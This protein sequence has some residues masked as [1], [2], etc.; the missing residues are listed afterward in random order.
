M[1]QKLIFSLLL[2][3]F[4]SLIAQEKSP[5]KFGNINPGDFNRKIYSIDSSATAIV[6]AN[7]GSTDIEGNSKGWFSLVFKRYARVHILNKNAYDV[8]N[9]SIPLFTDGDAEEQLDKLKAVTYNLED[10]KVVETKLDVKSNV[11]K[12]KINKNLV[13]KK[14]TFPNIKEG[15]IIEFEYTVTS[16][17]LQNLQPWEFQGEYPC[18]WSEYKL[19]LPAFFN[20][21]FLTQGYL[22]YDINEM[23]TGTTAF[24]VAVSEG[25]GRMERIRFE[26]PYTNYR[27]VMKNV[28]PLKEEAYTSTVSNYIAKIEFQ[29]SEYRQP[30]QYKRIMGTWSQLAE[31]LMRAEYFGQPLTKDNSW[32]KEVVHPVLDG[33]SSKLEKAKRIYGWVR[34]NMTCTD[35]SDKYLNQPLRNIVKAR[36]GTVAELNLLLAAMLR[37]QGIDA[38][39]VIL[40]TRSH[41]F[42][43]PLY[44]LLTRFNYVVCR[45]VID[46]KEY[47]LDA[48]EPR[49][50]FGYLP[51]RC[52]NGQARIIDKM[53]TA[54]ELNPE[55][56]MEK[57][58]TTVFL[59]NDDKGKLIGSFQQTPGYYESYSLR[60]KIKDKGVDE[61]LKDIK[62]NFGTA[63]EISEAHID[64]LDKYEH[65]MMVKY[66]FDIIDEFPDILY[67]NPILGEGYKSNPFKSEKRFYPIEM[68]YAFDETYNLQMEVP[69]GYEV[70]ELPQQVIVKLNE[71]GDGIFEY[72]LTRS[73]SSIS[74]R[75]RLLIRRSTFLPEEYEQLREFF[76]LIVRK[77]NEQIV[78]KKKK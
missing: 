78:F 58:T 40:S 46:G 1:K 45:A 69:V 26:S 16:D 19:M 13:V 74:F 33:T 77:H 53:G 49:M 62:K 71:E 37:H 56:I 31:D 29:L 42:V 72:R 9:I 55:A 65:E 30:L 18:L 32:I 68:P 76:S 21:V 43:Y 51:L 39:P 14:F 54:I 47:F 6:I 38:D 23:K 60:N 66:N 4:H 41:G 27:W 73:G 36:N 67:F 70:D 52:Y 61:L 57:K 48:S 59:I 2:L 75:S 3:S 15:S 64:S 35:Y 5:A 24:N 20:Y 17:F 25:T 44:P 22:K 7:I 34:D 63:I 28:P 50:G 8:A 12:D 10:G 11:F